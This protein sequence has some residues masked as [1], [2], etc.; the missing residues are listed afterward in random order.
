MEQKSAPATLRGAHRRAVLEHIAAS[1]ETSRAALSKAL[2][3]SKPAVSDILTSLLEEG[4]VLEAGAGSA[5]KGG[6]R[7][8]TML[9]LHA[10]YRYFAAADLSFSSPVFAVGDIAG[11]IL[12]QWEAQGPPQQETVASGLA[13]VLAESGVGASQLF[14]VMISAPGVYDDN[15]A[16]LAQN[17]KA[18]GVQWSEKLRSLVQARFLAPVF[19]MNDD[20]AAALGEWRTSPERPESLLY[21]SCGAGLG[22]GLILSGKPYCG[23]RFRA[24]E[25]YS[26]GDAAMRKRG[27][28][29]ESCLGME[30]LLR[31][32]ASTGAIREGDGFAALVRAYEGGSTQA[33][34]LVCEVMEALAAMSLNYAALLDAQQVVFGGEYRAFGAP[35]LEA[36]SVL[37][38]QD[39]PKIRLSALGG[40]AGI[41][42]LLYAGRQACFE[43]LQEG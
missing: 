11:H 13:R 9:R 34:R 12:A 5:Q 15:G 31:R 38:R 1:E 17:P 24:G 33:V 43:Q 4:I 18:Y 2:K 26:Y 3:L 25:I 36:V 16:L 28:T 41:H 23:S 32:A 20:N 29:A 37:A 14:A 19:V 10:G 27:E 40:A 21:I 6:G 30:A 8:P 7:R 42:G 22:A 35:Y 39:A